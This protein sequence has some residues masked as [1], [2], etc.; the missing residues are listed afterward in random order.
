M[1]KRSFIL[2]NVQSLQFWISANSNLPLTFKGIF[3][4]RQE[5]GK[6]EREMKVGDEWFRGKC[7][8]ERSRGYQERVCDDPSI[9]A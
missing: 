3:F 4:A 1:S 9:F 6:E 8:L 2:L 5:E 7:Q